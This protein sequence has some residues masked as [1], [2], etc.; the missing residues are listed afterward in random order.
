MV[1]ADLTL[2]KRV[3]WGSPD[4]RSHG[5]MLKEQSMLALVEIGLWR[6]V[7]D[8]SPLLEQKEFVRG[9]FRCNCQLLSF[10]RRRLKMFNARTSVYG[11]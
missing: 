3:Q 5:L 2:L 4:V 6:G 8:F 9:I 11:L 7:I 1:Q 10:S